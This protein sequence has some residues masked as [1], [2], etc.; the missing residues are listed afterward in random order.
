M[1]ARV[2]F[3]YISGAQGTLIT[4]LLQCPLPPPLP[5]EMDSIEIFSDRDEH[6]GAQVMFQLQKTG[7]RIV[8]SL[9]KSDTVDTSADTSGELPLVDQLIRLF[10][11]ALAIRADN[12]IESEILLGEALDP[13]FQA[14]D[15]IISESEIITEIPNAD[16]RLDQTSSLHTVLYPKTSH[17]RLESTAQLSDPI[18]VPIPAGE[19]YRISFDDGQALLDHPVEFQTDASLPRYSAHRI[20]IIGEISDGG[21]TTYLVTVDGQDKQYLCK[22]RRDGL[23]SPS[24]KQ[25]ID[26]LQKILQ[27]SSSLEGGMSRFRV[28]ALKGFVEH[29]ENGIIVGFLREWIPSKHNLGGTRSQA[30]ASPR[31][32]RQRWAGQTKRTVKALHAIGV[33]WGDAKPDNIV[34][35]LNEDA[36]VIDLGGGWSNGWVDA[37]LQGTIEGDEQGVS[38]IIEYWDVECGREGW[39]WQI[40]F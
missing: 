6:K 10:G 39:F 15:S 36:W 27:A 31:H 4:G 32:I 21:A 34:I 28:P 11:Q 29:P 12:Y 37:S 1:T 3:R 8:V 19:A 14:V 20:Q 26:C 7:E 25:E 13:I 2:Q 18:L 17:Y 5:F 40:C 35:D 9:F 33:V 30:L 23:R 24:L 16:D 22:A 38:R